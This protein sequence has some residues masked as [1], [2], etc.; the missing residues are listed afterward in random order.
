MNQPNQEIQDLY[1]IKIG[2]SIVDN[3]TS[4]S[5]F[6]KEFSVLK[7]HKILVHGG[8]D[9][10]TELAEQLG[11]P[12]TMIAGR[13][14]TS[15]ETLKIATMVYCGYIN[16]T[17][18]AQLQGMGVQALGVCGADLNLITAHKRIHDTI[19]Y[20]FVGDID[21]VN[22]TQ[23]QQ[24][25][26]HGI[27]VVCSAITHDH[28]GQLLNTNADTIAQSFAVAL[29]THYRVSLIYCFNKIGVLR[30]IKNPDTVIPNIYPDNYESLKKSGIIVDGM[31]PKIDNALQAVR[32]QVHRVII[33][34]GEYL[35]QLISGASGTTISL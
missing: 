24:L 23:A 16:K 1:I 14:V 13:R 12:Q 17:L 6:L 9:L 10:A 19:D 5:K 30:D 21:G 29:A 35:H 22:V 2:S 34:K 8:G 7:G 15:A 18:V 3:A 28:R 4:Q 26:N 11:I 33:G 20:G 27:T 25:L 32:Q 31:I